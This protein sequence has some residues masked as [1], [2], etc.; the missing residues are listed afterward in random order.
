M[1]ISFSR[2]NACIKSKYIKIKEFYF[3]INLK[4]KC[5]T[6]VES[7]VQLRTQD[8]MYYFIRIVSLLGVWSLQQGQFNDRVDCI[9][10]QQQLQQMIWSQES[11]TGLLS[12]SKQI[13][14]MSFS[15][16]EEGTNWGCGSPGRAG[17]ATDL[18]CSIT[19]L[20]VSPLGLPRPLEALMCTPPLE[21]CWKCEHIY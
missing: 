3:T 1:R 18:I 11:S 19:P 14:Q 2:F 21:S 15:I 8:F 6:R 20:G 12:T 4:C 10:V 5:Q 16:V 13:G 9:T 17:G 7:I